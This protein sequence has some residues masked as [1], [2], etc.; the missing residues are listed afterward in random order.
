VNNI[1]TINFPSLVGEE[2]KI[3]IFALDGRVVSMQ[4]INTQSV[5]NE[6]TINVS[7]LP[8]GLYLCL[9]IMG[10]QLKQLNL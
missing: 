4:I 3:E 10:K 6:T 2:V 8:V 5:T 9:L 7:S 1:L